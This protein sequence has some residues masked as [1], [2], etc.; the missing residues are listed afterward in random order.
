[1]LYIK[2]EFLCISKDSTAEIGRICTGQIMIGRMYRTD[3]SG[4]PACLVTGL[5]MFPRE[6]KAALL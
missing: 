2:S 1:M 3:E 6:I 4:Y 5:R